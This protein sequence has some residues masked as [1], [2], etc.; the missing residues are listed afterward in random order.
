MVKVRIQPGARLNV[1]VTQDRPQAPE[2]WTSQLPRLLEPQGVAAYVVESGRDAVELAESLELHAA[3]ID[4]ATPLGDAEDPRSW[5]ARRHSSSAGSAGLWLLE[6]FRRLPNRPPVVVV[7]GSDV[8]DAQVTRLL[9]DALRLG[10]FS[11]LNKPVDLEQLL[12]VFQRLLQRRYQ[13]AWP[14]RS[15]QAPKSEHPGEPSSERDA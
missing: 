4:M 9:N 15:S 13:G 10:A 6:L 12:V 7:H 3:V 1:L 8:S 14:N 11:V 2:H 5:S